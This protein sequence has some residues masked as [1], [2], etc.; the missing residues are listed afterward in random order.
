MPYPKRHEIYETVIRRM[1]T[2]SEGPA[3]AQRAAGKETREKQVE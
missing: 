2:E 3:A 1:V